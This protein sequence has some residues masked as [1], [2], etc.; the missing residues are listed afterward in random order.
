[1]NFQEMIGQNVEAVIPKF[2]GDQKLVTVKLHGVEAGGLWVEC[3]EVTNL[4][5]TETKAQS[6]PRTLVW[7][8]PYH[9]IT[10]V[11]SSI[12]APSLNEKAFQV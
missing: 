3:Q 7:F 4:V 6:A 1:M 8:V 5:L 9:E 2:G 10:L 11:L 12:D